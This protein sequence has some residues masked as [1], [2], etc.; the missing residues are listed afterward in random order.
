[1]GTICIVNNPLFNEDFQKSLQNYLGTL[2]S[3]YSSRR[4][5]KEYNFLV[6]GDY[7]RSIYRVKNYFFAKYRDDVITPYI[8]KF[9]VMLWSISI[10]E[11]GLLVMELDT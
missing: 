9:V 4:H 10:V 8:L 1:M 11:R 7:I 3:L 6:V 2:Y 5:I